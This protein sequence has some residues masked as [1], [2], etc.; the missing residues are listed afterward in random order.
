MLLLNR[1]RSD[2]QSIYFNYITSLEKAPLADKDETKGALFK[3]EIRAELLRIIK[4]YEKLFIAENILNLAEKALTENILKNA[5][6]A[7]TIDDVLLKVLPPVLGPYGKALKIP[8]RIA[9]V[10]ATIEP[11]GLRNELTFE[12]RHNYE[13]DQ[14][15]MHNIIDLVCILTAATKIQTEEAITIRYKQYAGIALGLAAGAA[16]LVLSPFIGQM[17]MYVLLT[18]AALSLLCTLGYFVNSLYKVSSNTAAEEENSFT[19][20]DS[21]NSYK[22]F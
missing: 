12:L 10:V 17:L 15:Q 18:I 4:L 22:M 3:Q 5:N 7:A 14:E 11:W 6:V 13:H 9:H 1:L 16:A 21:L 2:L 20:P 8:Q 19:P